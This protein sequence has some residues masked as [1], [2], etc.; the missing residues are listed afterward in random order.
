MTPVIVLSRYAHRYRGIIEARG[1]ADASLTFAETVEEALPA[2]AGAEVLFGAPD[3]L[4]ELLPHCPALR[5]IQSSWAGVTPLLA[6]PRRDYRLSG[7]KDI[8][9]PPMSEYVLG[10][11]LALERNI[12]AHFGATRW[13]PLRDGHLHG[14]TVGI[15][16]T[17]SIGSHVAASCRALGLATR[18]L[19]SD[20]RDV[21]GFDRCW[22]TASRLAFARDL[23]YLVALL[24]DTPATDGLVDHELLARLSPAAIFINGGRGNAVITAD[25]VGALEDGAVRHAVLD[26]LPAEPLADDDPLWQVPGLTITSHT[27]APTPAEAIVE[28]FIDNYRRYVAGDALRYEI[29]FE[30]GY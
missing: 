18:G 30:R 10:W 8:F 17:G 16:G 6:L 5:W 26:V 28:I 24:P 7:V 2:A 15:M 19:N 12:P 1:L 20:G 27:A 25:L 23:D 14:K 21:P 13:Q 29:D 3:Q 22:P 4:A 11:L 9:G